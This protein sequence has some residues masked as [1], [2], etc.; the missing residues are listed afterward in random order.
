MTPAYLPHVAMLHL[1][2]ETLFVKVL[3]LL[4]GNVWLKIYQEGF[5]YQYIVQLEPKLTLNLTN[6]H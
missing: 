6:K 5:L 1:S 4:G 2:L 3:K